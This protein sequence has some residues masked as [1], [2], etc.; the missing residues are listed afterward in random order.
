MA[1]LVDKCG[2]GVMLAGLSDTSSKVQ[3]SAAN[4][5]NQLLSTP[6]LV[7]RA[8]CVCLGV[9]SALLQASCHHRTS[10]RNTHKLQTQHT[11]TH[12]THARRAALAT[13]DRGVVSAVMGLLDH[14]LPL[15]RA[16]GI[17]AVVLLCRWGG[18]E[19]VTCI[20]C[21]AGVAAKE[22]GAFS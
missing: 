12:H 5:L 9:G 8:R 2:A 19:P 20:H 10:I 17:L 3:I 11:R 1:G 13:D 7:S 18:G 4:M 6:E 14:A 16:K 22:R 15:L 21:I